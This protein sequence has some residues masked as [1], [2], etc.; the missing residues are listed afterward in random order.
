MEFC[1]Y[2]IS[3][4]AP[5]ANFSYICNHLRVLNFEWL[6]HTLNKLV[7]KNHWNIK[8]LG[9]LIKLR[10]QLQHYVLC[11]VPWSCSLICI[12]HRRNSGKERYTQVYQSKTA[13]TTVHDNS[14]VQSL[15]Y[16]F[17]NWN[18]LRFVDRNSLILLC[19]LLFNFT[20][21]VVYLYHCLLLLWHFLKGL[22]RVSQQIQIRPGLQIV[23][24]PSNSLSTCNRS[25][26]WS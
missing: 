10:E 9:S 3:L 26:L 12:V 17:F 5:T 21:P 16:F 20:F 4:F 11:N 19:G 15:Q 25:I 24:T 7:W 13:Q 1:N 2:L 18:I 22:R 8:I 14:L 23:H 6:Q